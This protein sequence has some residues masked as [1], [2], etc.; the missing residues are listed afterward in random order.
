VKKF[1]FK[2]VIEYVEGL[3]LP[4][5]GTIEPDIRFRESTKGRLLEEISNHIYQSM[6]F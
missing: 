2:V 3:E 5:F 1:E 6:E 4:W